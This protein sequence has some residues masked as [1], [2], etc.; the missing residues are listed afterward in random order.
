V[1]LPAEP[2]ARRLMPACAHDSP[3][4]WPS[5]FNPVPCHAPAPTA[6]TPRL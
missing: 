4:I 2:L 5:A 3:V 1:A 6:T